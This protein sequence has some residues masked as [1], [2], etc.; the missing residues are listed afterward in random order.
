MYDLHRELI[1][2]LAATPETITGLLRG[3]DEAQARSAVGGDENWS[4]IEVIC[5]L[6]DAEEIGFG[7]MQ[8]M[9]DQDKPIVAGWDQNALALEKKYAEADLAPTLAAFIDTR[10][11]YV[12]ALKALTPEQWERS[13]KHNETGDITILTHALHRAYHDAIHCAQIARQILGD[14]AI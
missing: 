12:A 6:R 3:V 1:E 10:T 7:R 13:G 4:V 5:H 2:T 9:R 14:S 11:Q 8:A